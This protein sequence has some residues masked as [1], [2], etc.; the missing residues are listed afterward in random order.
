[1]TG[2][3]CTKFRDFTAMVMM[4][5]T[6]AAAEDAPI[7]IGVEGNGDH[8]DHI[9][10]H[11]GGG[12]CPAIA[13][14]RYATPDLPS[15]LEGEVLLLCNALAVGGYDAPLEFV[16]G[17]S[18]NRSLADSVAGRLDMPSQTVWTAE[19]A[20]H[21]DTL[22]ASEPVFSP[23]EWVMGLFTTEHRDD[24]LAVE[25]PQDLRQLV[26]AA[27]RGWVE[28]WRALSSLDLAGLIDVQ[29]HRLIPS[30][31]AAGHAD[32]TLFRISDAPDMG[33]AIQN[34]PT[35]MIPIK[36][37]KLPFQ[38]GRHFA[39]SRSR[40]DAEDLK[41]ALDRGLEALRHTPD[42]AKIM[43][44]VGF[45]DPRIADWVSVVPEPETIEK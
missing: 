1:M 19:L 35:R 8:A 41:E 36:G 3:L 34:P 42:F 40:A 27:P 37:L 7:R 15:R 4:L 33:F 24:V 28:D 13:D 38:T 44:D 9:I 25:T 6:A 45:R 10:D 18:Y 2:R 14:Y 43:T 16:F 17:F 22:L 31:I 5:G 12:S 32:F 23:G 26:A 11:F 39:I 21:A 30:M 29:D 20:D